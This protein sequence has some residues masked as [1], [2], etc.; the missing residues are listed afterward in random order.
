MWKLIETFTCNASHPANS[1][2]MHWAVHG[3]Y[4]PPENF[5]QVL[6]VFRIA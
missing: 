5:V 2:R 1:A 3:N 4:P 6:M